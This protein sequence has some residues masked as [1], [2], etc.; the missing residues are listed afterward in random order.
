[1]LIDEEQIEHKSKPKP[2]NASFLTMASSHREE[3]AD[4]PNHDDEVASVAT[5][6]NLEEA[7]KQ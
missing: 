5:Y 1:V 2:L 3:D 7:L 6:S 4:Q